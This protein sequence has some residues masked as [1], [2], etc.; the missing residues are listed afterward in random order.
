MI[1]KLFF[2]EEIQKLVGWPKM[3]VFDMWEFCFSIAI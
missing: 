1:Y 2:I 3:N